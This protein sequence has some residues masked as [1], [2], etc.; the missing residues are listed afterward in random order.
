MQRRGHGAGNKGKKE[1]ARTHSEE[2]GMQG[3]W[4]RRLGQRSEKYYRVKV[5]VY[6][7]NWVLEYSVFIL[8]PRLWS[9][10]C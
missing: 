6:W 1:L 5:L 3:H 9:G 7:I 2:P 10:S 8:H 4:G